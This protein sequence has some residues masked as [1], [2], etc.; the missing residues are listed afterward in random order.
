M[1]DI[2]FA[3]LRN[4]VRLF[5]IHDATL[6]GGPHDPHAKSADIVAHAAY[7]AAGVFEG[8]TVYLRKMENVSDGGGLQRRR[9]EPDKSRGSYFVP[10]S[11]VLLVKWRAE[12]GDEKAKR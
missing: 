1:A 7:N 11:N 4:A 8:L 9:G 5:N 2:E 12:T 10:A 6:I 3:Q